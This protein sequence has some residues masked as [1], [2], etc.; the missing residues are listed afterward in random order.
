[1]LLI[2]VL[3]S[4]GK[5]SEMYSEC[6]AYLLLYVND[7]HILFEPSFLVFPEDDEGGAVLS[8]AARVGILGMAPWDWMHRAAALLA[9]AI[10]S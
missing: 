3:P 9:H 1:M 4:S 5:L 8:M 6:I 2:L 7:Y 10:D